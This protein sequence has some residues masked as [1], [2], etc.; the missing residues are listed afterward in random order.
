M[1]FGAFLFLAAT[2]HAQI[3]IGE[4]VT[5]GGRIGLDISYYQRINSTGLSDPFRIR[6][7]AQPYFKIK[8]VTIRT[9]I[10]VGDYHK[11]YA[12]E[13]NKFGTS[14]EYRSLKLYVG[15][16]NQNIT[17]MTL[18]GHTILGGGIEL[19]PGVFRF[20]ASYG[21]FRRDINPS[22]F[23]DVFARA[24]YN[25]W[26]LAGKIGF[27]KEYNFVDLIILRV[28]DLRSSL[29]AA[30]AGP[31]SPAQNAILSIHTKQRIWKKLELEGEFAISAF[32]NDLRNTGKDTS[33][34]QVSKAAGYLIERNATTDYAKAIRAAI[35]YQDNARRSETGF[36]PMNGFSISLSYDRIDP[37]YQSMGTYYLRNDLQRLKLTSQLRFQK[38]NLVF[39]PQAGWETTDLEARRTAKTNR[40]LGGLGASIRIKQNTFVN[41]SYMNFN[42]ALES[43]TVDSLILRKVSHNLQ[44]GIQNQH[45]T[46][47]GK[48]NT[49]RFN[50][51][52]QTGRN[53]SS[54]I[55][56]LYLGSINLQTSYSAAVAGKALELQPS[57]RFNSYKRSSGQQYRFTPGI[58]TRSTFLEN[59]MSL[60]YNL[61]AV[62]ATMRSTGIASTSLRND[63]RWTYRF[64]KKQSISMRIS[65]QQNFLKDSMNFGDFRGDLRY[66][67][68]L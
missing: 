12:Q 48:K 27:G 4:N 60:T 28:G 18:Q 61:A 20:S 58:S 14:V 68:N 37:D 62:L 8:D 16:F 41:L 13:F 54:E 57:F 52:Y 38:G 45:E 39:T 25:R 63:V 3:K 67:F 30:S 6:F 40:F 19:N 50:A 53:K 5:V 31:V 9:N 21:R 42:N 65:Y 1:V 24:S 66:T 23:S 51:G 36:R 55:N 2:A 35:S 59:K 29:D 56:S 10:V 43:N 64:V 34:F 49:F 33:S 11:K 46:G 17:P 26:G 47:R 32:T 44:G 22:D 7:S 15:H